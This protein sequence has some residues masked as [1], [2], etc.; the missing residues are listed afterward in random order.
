MPS[1]GVPLS[2]ESQELF[3]FEW[4]DP[5]FKGKDSTAEDFSEGPYPSAA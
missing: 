1:F 5:D 2:P 3:A 4:E